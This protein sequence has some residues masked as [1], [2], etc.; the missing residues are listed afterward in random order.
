MPPQGHTLEERD[1]SGMWSRTGSRQGPEDVGAEAPGQ[2]RRTQQPARGWGCGCGV[3]SPGRPGSLLHKSACQA[4]PGCFVPWLQR[5]FPGRAQA[6]LGAGED[7]LC[8][9]TWPAPGL[10]DRAHAYVGTSARLMPGGPALLCLLWDGGLLDSQPD[11]GWVGTSH[12][13]DQGATS[14][15]SCTCRGFWC[16]PG[17]PGVAAAACPVHWAPGSLLLTSHLTAWRSGQGLPWSQ[18]QTI[19]GSGSCSPPQSRA[20]T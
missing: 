3:W 4:G 7:P 6:L 14:S 9:P 17:H 12:P 11:E 8:S 5:L 20:A 15:P 19:H 2:G 1:T 18:A 16:S 13:D 10:K